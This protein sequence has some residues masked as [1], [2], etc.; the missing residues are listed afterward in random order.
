MSD[1][2]R[3][4]RPRPDE[5][6]DWEALLKELRGDTDE[7]YHIINAI[8]GSGET[9][10]DARQVLERMANDPGLRSDIAYADSVA[11]LQIVGSKRGPG[12]VV[13][14]ERSGR[15]GVASVGV[16]WLYQAAHDWEPDYD[17]TKP[18]AELRALPPTGRDLEAHGFSI[19]GVE[20]EAFTVRRHVD[21]AGLYAQLGIGLNWRVPVDETPVLRRPAAA[22]DAGASEPAGE[23]ASPPT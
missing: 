4:T 10:M 14:D 22:P 17:P 2:E 13:D 1:F 23:D 16:A 8:N 6:P 18:N 3:T 5:T 19:F 9:D 11:M 15:I 12:W 7:T 21:W 20:N